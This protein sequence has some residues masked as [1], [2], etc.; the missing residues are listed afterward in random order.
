[1]FV[2]FEFREQPRSGIRMVGKIAPHMIDVIIR[3]A[4]EHRHMRVIDGIVN[5]VALT[6]GFHQMFFP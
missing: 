5:E 4:E 1:M 3:F 6:P 2:T